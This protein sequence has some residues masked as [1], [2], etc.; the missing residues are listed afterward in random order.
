[1]RWTDPDGRPRRHARVWLD[2]ATWRS[3]LREPLDA[4]RMAALDAWIA[5]GRAA[6]ARRRDPASDIACDLAVAL[7]LSA[8]RARIGFAVDPGAIVRIAPPLTLADTIARAPAEW[9]EALTDLHDRAARIGTTFHVYG[10]LAWQAI[11]NEPCART[12]SDVDLL[13]TAAS[14][15]DVDRVLALLAEWEAVGPLRAD[16]ELLLPNG[17]AIAWRELTQPTDRVLVKHQDRVSLQ[18]SPSYWHARIAGLAEH[19]A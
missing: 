2:R 13:W 1:M 18:P 19:D 10:S 9:R 17:D 16:G 12:G 4:E 6:V 8:E 11:S 14:I 5:A 15:D 7:P 3:A